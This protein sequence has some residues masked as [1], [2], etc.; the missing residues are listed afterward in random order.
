MQSTKTWRYIYFGFVT[1]SSGKIDSEISHRVMKANA[2]YKE[3]SNIVIGK[4]EVG[5][6]K[7]TNFLDS[8]PPYN[9]LQCRKLGAD[10]L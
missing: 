6:G 8:Q 7:I 9:T 4:K 2:V 5:L 10:R 1:H 3:I